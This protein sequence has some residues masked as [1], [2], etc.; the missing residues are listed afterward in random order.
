M[1]IDAHVHYH[2]L[3]RSYDDM[4]ILAVSDDLESSRK[5]LSLARRT[6]LPCVGVHPWSVESSSLK[7][8]DELRRIIERKEII[9]LGEIGLDRRRACSYNRQVE[10]FTEQLR[11]AADFSLPVNLHA[12]DAWREV[13]NMLDRYE[14]ERAIFHWFTGPLDLLEE[15]RSRG[16][17][18]TINPAVVVQ[19][20]HMKILLEAP[21]DMMLTESDGPYIYRGIRLNPSMIPWLI[22]VI[23]KVKGINTRDLKTMFAE[24]LSRFVGRAIVP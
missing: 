15:L 23:S 17:F 13:L 2:E 11:I 4:M 20:K 8:L 24:N 19:E 12:L 3:E 10:F 6:V 1:L 22:S 16:Y 18:I 21:L 14:I 5:T 9:C 7:D